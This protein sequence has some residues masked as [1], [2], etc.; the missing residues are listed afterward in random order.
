MWAGMAAL[1]DTEALRMRVEFNN[2]AIDY[3]EEMLGSVPGLDV[4]HSYGNYILMDGTD[5]GKKGKDMVAFAQE[6]GL[7]L[8]P[9]NPMYD[10]D[11]WFRITI[12]SEDENR[13]A[14]E[15]IREFLT[16]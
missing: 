6:K 4:Y 3:Y 13:M 12:G 11:G 10:R 8:R 7:I 15:A 16:T 1:E 5:T 14:V 9:Q 2:R